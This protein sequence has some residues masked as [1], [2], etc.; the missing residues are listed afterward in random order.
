MALP[1]IALVAA[2]PALAADDDKSP[3]AASKEGA[4]DAKDGKDAKDGDGEKSEKT[5]AGASASAAASESV[6]TDAA[7]SASVGGEASGAAAEPATA[8]TSP[9]SIPAPPGDV[10]RLPGEAYPNEPIRGIEGGSLWMTFHG[11]QWPVSPF[12]TDT[13]RTQLG[14]SGS[15]WVDTGYKKVDSGTQG[16]AD[17]NR[18]ITQ[19]RFVL[20]VTPT[21]TKGDWFVQGQGELVA[22]KDQTVSQPNVADTDDLWLRAGRWNKWDVQVGRFEAWELYHLG[23]GLDLNT[24]EREGANDGQN[25][26][27]PDFYGVTFAYYRPSGVGNVAFHAYPTKFLRAE[28]LGQIGNQSSLNTLAVRPAVVAD[29]GI[30]KLKGGV[31]YLKVTGQADDNQTDQ[32]LKGGGGAVQVVLDPHVEFGVNGAYAIVDKIDAQGRV[33]TEGSITTYS[34]GGFANARVVGPVLVG[35]GANYTRVDDLHDEPPPSNLHGEFSHLQAFGAVQVVVLDQLFIKAVAAYAKADF[36]PTFTMSEPYQNT[37]ISGR[38][39]L[40]Y[41]F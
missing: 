40:M 10:A 22:N 35:V 19:G 7:A 14:F 20:R 33:D 36:A 18:L 17:V 26:P 30:V 24:V 11:L 1:L 31:E 16:A 8:A 39:R 34:V 29:F 23:M 25:R 13:P 6:G 28:L 9:G 37:A 41:L 27:P 12:H 38:L 4:S 32:Q 21:Y 3:D 5:E 15:A 2:R